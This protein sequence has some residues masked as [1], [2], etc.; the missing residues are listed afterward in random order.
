M[1]CT[2]PADQPTTLDEA[3][4]RAICWAQH[5]L[6]QEG[7]PM[8]D[9]IWW[10]S[11]H[12]VA[13]DQVLHRALRDKREYRPTI[14]AQRRRARRIEAG[15]WALDRHVTGDARLAQYSLSRLAGDLRREVREY[16]EAESLLLHAIASAKDQKALAVEYA[17]AIRHAPTRPHPL[18]HGSRAMRGVLLRIEAAIDHGRDVMDSRHV[19][20]RATAVRR[21]R[22]RNP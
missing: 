4:K 20:V 9:A 18:T 16:A 11:T 6:S 3:A 12:L 10:L 2:P 5:S 7:R 13:T 14:V 21:T 19:P 22:A 15:L 17:A 1:T 8:L